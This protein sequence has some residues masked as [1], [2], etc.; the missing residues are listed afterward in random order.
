VLDYRA[1]D[2]AERLAAACPGGAGLYV[3]T[4]GANDLE[5]ALP[6]LAPRGRLVLMAGARSRPV[7]PAADLYMYDRS[8]IGF[9]ISHATVAELAE[10]AAAV[11]RL[12]AAGLLHPRATVELPLSATADA[13]RMLERG[14]LRGRRAVL[15][16]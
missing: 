9:V 4:S 10:A 2:L 7:L 14:E 13:H 6:L 15:R 1:P 8:I 3:D 5:T 16:P 11:N 12:L